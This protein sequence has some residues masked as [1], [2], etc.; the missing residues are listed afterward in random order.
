MGGLALDRRCGRD[1]SDDQRERVVAAARALVIKDGLGALSVRKVAR[2]AGIGASTLRYYFPSQDGLYAAVIGEEFD[3]SLSDVRIHDSS[4]DAGDRLV[5][6]LQQFLPKSPRDVN[7]ISQWTAGLVAANPHA[8]PELANQILD[9]V[10]ERAHARVA[11]WLELLHSEGSLTAK[12]T[13]TTVS[14]LCALVNGLS[15]DLASSMPSVDWDEATDIV[16]SV[17]DKFVL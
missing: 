13:R 11:Y 2:E 15:M 4:V 17:V 3:H 10:T 12:Q 16:R 14:L 1:V 7:V 8:E 6:C 5:E 9:L